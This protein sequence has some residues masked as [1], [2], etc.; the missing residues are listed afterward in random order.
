M[1]VH[2]QFDAMARKVYQGKLRHKLVRLSDLQKLHSTPLKII[3][4]AK[5]QPWPLLD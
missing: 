3:F 2:A 5:Y 1:L 4:L